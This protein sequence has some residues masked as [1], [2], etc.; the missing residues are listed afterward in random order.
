M[1]TFRNIAG[2]WKSGVWWRNIA[3]TWKRTN[4][5]RRIGTVWKNLS[6]V[7]TPDGGNQYYS[8]Q[9]FAS[10]TLYCSVPA[11]WTYSFTAGNGGSVNLASGAT[12]TSITFSN[13][14]TGPTGNRQSRSATWA[15]SATA[16]G[17]TQNW[18]VTVEAFGDNI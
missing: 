7:F 17:I 9:D 15:V 16:N 2:T 1:A 4:T 10:G 5:W 6:V 12:S 11:V 13:S 8:S 3:G 18:T 14:A